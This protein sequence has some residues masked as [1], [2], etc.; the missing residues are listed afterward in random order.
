M[1]DSRRGFGLDIGHID[2]FNTQLVIIL[3]YSNIANLHTLQITVTHT[4]FLSL[5]LD[6][7]W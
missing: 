2:Y 6:V 5:L 7:S 4:N 3:N 1:S